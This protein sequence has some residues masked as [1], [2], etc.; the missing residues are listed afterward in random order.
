MKQLVHRSPQIGYSG[1][2][3]R[4]NHTSVRLKRKVQTLGRVKIAQKLRAQNNEEEE[5]DQSVEEHHQEL[6]TKFIRYSRAGPQE[7]RYWQQHGFE[8][9]PKDVAFA[10]RMWSVYRNKKIRKMVNKGKAKKG[11]VIPEVQ[12]PNPMLYTCEKYPNA[13]PVKYRRKILGLQTDPMENEFWWARGYWDG[14][15]KDVREYSKSYNGKT[16]RERLGMVQVKEFIELNYPGVQVNSRIRTPY[17][18]REEFREMLDRE[19][20]SLA[21]RIRPKNLPTRGRNSQV[22]ITWSIVLQYRRMKAE[23]L[24]VLV[25]KKQAEAQRHKIMN[26]FQLEVKQTPDDSKPKYRSDSLGKKRRLQNSSA[27]IKVKLIGERSR[28]P[29]KFDQINEETA[30]DHVD[31]LK[32]VFD[33]I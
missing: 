10:Y 17:F 9:M 11:T 4:G 3:Y 14:V 7:V 27:P 31:K 22:L 25:E 18:E 1:V 23:T 8:R 6:Y 32:A 29:T 13:C 24:K 2:R 21:N 33:Q 20:A 12:P 19:T 26:K 30:G 15:P 16:Y 5:G 28:Q